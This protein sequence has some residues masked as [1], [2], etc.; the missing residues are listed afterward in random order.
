MEK[1]KLANMALAAFV[2]ASSLPAVSHAKDIEIE[3]T[4]LAGG[5]ASSSKG[6]AAATGRGCAASTGR[7]CAATTNPNPKATTNTRSTQTYYETA[8]DSNVNTTTRT[9][10]VD[11]T[12]N[13]PNANP[14]NRPNAAYDTSGRPMTNYDMPARPSNYDTTTEY[15][16]TSTGTTQRANYNPN[17]TDNPYRR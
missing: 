10:E 3:G 16:S 17:N 7:G 11:S 12:Y 14:A 8:P 9:Y 15:R 13:R 4:L 5:C 2:L 1:K 6:C